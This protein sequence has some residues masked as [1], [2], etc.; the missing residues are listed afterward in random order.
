MK[1]ILLPSHEAYIL[2][3]IQMLVRALE[4]RGVHC[5]NSPLRHRAFRAMAKAAESC[6][7]S[8]LPWPKCREPVFFHLNHVWPAAFY[9]YVITSPLVTFSFDCWPY[10][11]DGWH[12]LF[13]RNKPRIAF[14]SAKKSVLEM[15]R[16]LPEIDFRWLPEA[17]D[18]TGFDG[19]IP[20]AERPID[21]LEIGRSYQDYH[22]TIREPLSLKGYR[23]DYPQKNSGAM[24]SYQDAVRAYATSKVVVCFPKSITAPEQAGGVET[25]T[26]RY[27]ECMFS[28]A[29][30]IGHCPSELID[31]LGYNPVIEAD[32]SNPPEQLMKEV[33]C[34]IG[35]YQAFVD[36]NYASAVSRWTVDHQASLI[37][38]AMLE[39]KGCPNSDNLNHFTSI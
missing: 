34:K 17:L 20:L 22:E 11:Y 33:L 16:R 25:T 36:K 10:L 29:L 5:Y 24:L 21:V 27:F 18:P 35:E 1:Q 15:R 9:P 8:R 4:R 7:L 13:H 12:N 23:H 30:M 38:N 31:I 32:M 28:K 14:I 6:G 19:S 39:I 3:T 2:P 37:F 26:F